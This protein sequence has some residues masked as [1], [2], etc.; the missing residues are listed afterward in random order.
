M[1]GRPKNKKSDVFKH[2]KINKETDCWVWQGS[3][4]SNNP[5]GQFMV[6]RKNYRV[7]RLSYEVS[8]KVTLLSST[9]VCHSCD[10]P[11]CINPN[12]LFLGTHQDNRNDCISKGRQAN[13]E[14][15]NRCKLTKKEVLEIRAKF[16]K[17]N[18]VEISKEYGV[19]PENINCIIRRKT[20]KHI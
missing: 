3:Y 19:T 8:N 4:F 11:K 20:W 12:H 15:I 7:H 5:Y 2:Y 17:G 13:G 18:S 1:T 9:N 10:N 16:K 6:N 14:Q